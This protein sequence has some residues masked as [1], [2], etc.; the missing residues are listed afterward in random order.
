MW[1]E[2]ATQSTQEAEPWSFT[3]TV[4]AAKT[5]VRP[6]MTRWIVALLTRLGGVITGMGDREEA[7]GIGDF[8]DFGDL[9]D[10]GG[11]CGLGARGGGHGGSFT[12]RVS[13]AR[14]RRR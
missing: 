4:T 2:T 8:G 1:V 11:F 14:P 12:A 7:G 5:S 13:P 6:R 9:G 3:I 10:F